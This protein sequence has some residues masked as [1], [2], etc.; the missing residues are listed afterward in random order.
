VVVV[1]VDYR[2]GPLGFLRVDGAGDGDAGRL[3]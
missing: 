2:L 3:T 1:G